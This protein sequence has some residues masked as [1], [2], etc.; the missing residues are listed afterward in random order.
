MARHLLYTREYLSNLLGV[1][2]EDLD[3]DFEPD[4]F[5]H[6]A[7]LPEILTQGG[8]KYYYHCRGHED[9]SIFRWKAPSGASV[10]VFR[11]SDW[12][13]GPITY[14]MVLDVPSYCDANHTDIMMKVYGVGDHG[15]GPTRRDI[16]RIREMASWPLMPEIGLAACVTSLRRLKKY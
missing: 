10:L 2:R 14:D 5:G 7:N 15:G 16:E 3:L 13:L 1:K 12:Y 11:G 4:T 8:V 6:S 9:H